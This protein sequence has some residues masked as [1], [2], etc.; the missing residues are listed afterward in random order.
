MQKFDFFFTKKFLFLFVVAVAFIIFFHRLSEAPLSGDGIGYGEIA[1]EM[2][3]TG[4]YLTPYHDGLPSFYTSKPPML[5]WFSALSGNV[6]GFNNFSVKLPVAILAFLSIISMFLFVSKYYNFNVAFFTSIVLTFTQQYM[7]HGRS[8]V[9]DGPFATFFI[10]ALISFWVANAEQK[11]LCYYLMSFFIG[12]AV[13]T[14]QVFGFIPFFV[15]FSYIIIARDFKILKNY[16]FY[17]SFFIVPLIVLPWH[18]LM[19]D[20]FGMKFINEYFLSTVNNIQG[21]SPKQSYFSGIYIYINILISNYQPWV[22]F[23]IYGVY[24]KFKNIKNIIISK[25]D[26]FILSWFFIPFVILHLVTQKNGNYLNAL[27]PASAIICAEVFNSFSQRIVKKII[28]ILLILSTALCITY[29]SFPIIPLT[30]DSQKLRDPMGLIQSVK[31]IDSKNKIII[32]Q[33]DWFV[34][35]SL[36]LF[37]ADR[38]NVTLDNS[39]FEQEFNSPKKYYFASYKDEFMNYLLSKYKN[40]INILCETKRTILFTNENEK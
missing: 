32:R 5:Y 29:I 11:N 4:D 34:F 23:F 38:G 13:M 26:I 10:F 19:Y 27:Y 25:K 21:W 3:I 7:H 33:D 18:I 35:S 12:C 31:T 17:L 9:T 28:T 37:Y 8:C 24:I 30:L 22:L 39:K 2:A 16:H 36:F 15:V 40:K 1:K 6:F 14:K 20:K